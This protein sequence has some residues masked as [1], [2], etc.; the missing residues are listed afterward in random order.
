MTT[1]FHTSPTR[2]RLPGPPTRRFAISWHEPQPDGKRR[3]VRIWGVDAE[4]ETAAM[5]AAN[6]IVPRNVRPLEAKE[7]T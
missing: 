5:L 6:K 4:S 1:T 3:W 7:E 2:R